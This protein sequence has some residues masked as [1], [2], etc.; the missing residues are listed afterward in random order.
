M[1][2]KDPKHQI[3]CPF[4]STESRKCSI[5]NDGLFI[6][7]DDHVEAFCKTSHFSACNRY[8][9]YSENQ[10]CLQ[11]RVR[12]SEENRRKYMRTATSHDITLVKIFKSKQL[13]SQFTYRAKMID[14]SKGGL[15]MAIKN[16]LI[17]DMMVH[18]SFDDSFPQALHEVTGR[19]EWCNKQ[20]DE[21]GYQAGVSF[22][23]DDILEAIGRHLRKQNK[24]R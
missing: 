21:P 14:V 11:E 8:T 15:R 17:H 12:K 4:W 6:P 9:L 3:K 5:G 23:G 10:I 22:K 20:I 13:K 2:A 19:V 18:C 24:Q 7:L 16:P 1:T